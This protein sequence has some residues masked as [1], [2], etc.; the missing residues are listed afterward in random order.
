MDHAETIAKRVLEI[1]L[2]GT[3]EYQPEQSHGECDFELRYHSGTIAA[4]EVT[5]SVDEIQVQTMAAISSSKKGGSVIQ[6]INCQ[7]SWVVFPAREANINEIRAKIDGH[8]S[9]VEQAGIAKFFCIRDK[10]QCV[11]DLCSELKIMSGSI[12]PTEA[13]PKIRIAFPAG[14]GA[15]GPSIAT[16]A[17]ENEAWKEDN[18]KKLG[19]PK[20]ADRHLF[21]YIDIINRQP[22]RAPTDFCPPFTTPNLPDQ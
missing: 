17:G 6:A 8:L 18:R 16:E 10:S 7:Q 3:M 14:G 13:P 11:Q 15:V 20:T 12:L 22:W 4:V 1:I 2:P 9:K 5:S 21:A 19:A